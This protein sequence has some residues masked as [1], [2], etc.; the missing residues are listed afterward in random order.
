[1]TR[2]QI[3]EMFANIDAA[4]H[5]F[6]ESGRLLREAFTAHHAAMDRAIDANRATLELL[7]RMR[8]DRNK[9]KE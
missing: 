3:D 9:E 8:D 7:K 1:M 4:K 5:D 2:E 6:Q